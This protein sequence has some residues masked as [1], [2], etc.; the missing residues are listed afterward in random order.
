M[1]SAPSSSPPLSQTDPYHNRIQEPSFLGL[2][3]ELRIAIYKYAFADEPWN[4]KYKLAPYALTR[5]NRQIRHESM[6]LYYT[7]VESLELP[8]DAA[9]I[10]H[11]RDWLRTVDLAAFPKLP[12]F[13][14]MFSIRRNDDERDAVLYADR[15][16]YC[17]ANALQR[18]M[19][20]GYDNAVTRLYREYIGHR[21]LKLEPDS[22]IGEGFEHFKEVVE[23]D[24]LWVKRGFGYGHCLPWLFKHMF[25]DIAKRMAGRDWD[26]GALEEI[27]DAFEHD[28]PCDPDTD[29][30]DGADSECFESEDSASDDSDSN[31]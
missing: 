14:F 10:S 1:S 25:A 3:A 6:P 11:T 8:V 5:V 19:H 18:Y 28:L 31:E 12:N 17:P 9:N 2:P 20:M 26:K 21:R 23:Q 4:T 24:G 30:S 29:E 7:F 13:V 27:L 22:H 15:D 16:V